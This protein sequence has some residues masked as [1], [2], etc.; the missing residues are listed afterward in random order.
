MNLSEYRLSHNLTQQSLA[1]TVGVTQKSISAY[2]KGERRPSPEVAQ[3]IGA[4]L[5]FDWTRF[6]T[7]EKGEP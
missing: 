3:K 6:F 7:E 1:K 4:V 2:E 5:G